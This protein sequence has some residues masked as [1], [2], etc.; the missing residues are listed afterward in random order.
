MSP[1]TQYPELKDMK[2][3]EIFIEWAFIVKKDRLIKLYLKKIIPKK[4]MMI[5]RKALRSEYNL[6]TDPDN[7]HNNEIIDMITI[8]K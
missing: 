2:S 4:E 8:E 6:Y 5:F 1:E 7:K 3:S